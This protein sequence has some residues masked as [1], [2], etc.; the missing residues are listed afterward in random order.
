MHE[1]L[2]VEV[3]QILVVHMKNQC[4]II[5]Q[6]ILSGPH[7]TLSFFAIEVEESQPVP[8]PL[9]QSPSLQ[10]VGVAL[11]DASSETESEGNK[12]TTTNATSVKESSS[13]TNKRGKKRVSRR[14]KK[15]PKAP[16]RFKSSYIFYAK[17]KYKEIARELAEQGITDKVSFFLRCFTNP[18]DAAPTTSQP[19]LTRGLL[20]GMKAPKI[21]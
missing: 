7:L 18:S 16:K 12:K 14:T 20:E 3:R 13:S 15:D 5:I 4:A 17:T 10:P 9:K 21:S 2:L 1:N 11:Q 6:T 19:P 8:P